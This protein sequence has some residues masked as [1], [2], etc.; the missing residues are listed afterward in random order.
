MNLP[1][2]LPMFDVV[3]VLFIFAVGMLGIEIVFSILSGNKILH[4]MVIHAFVVSSIIFFSLAFCL[5]NMRMER[6]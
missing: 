6:E 3:I 5:E 4:G 1:T 2:E